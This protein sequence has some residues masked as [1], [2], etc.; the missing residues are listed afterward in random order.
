[1][2]AIPGPFVGVSVAAPARPGRV[3]ARGPALPRGLSRKAQL[4][5]AAAVFL[6]ISKFHGFVGVL[7]T[8]RAPFILSIIGLAM[9]AMQMNRWR[10]RDL[11]RHWIPKSTLV[12]LVI[13]TAG[14][15]LA[16]NDGK[17]FF[18]MKDQVL[19]V[20]LLALM[21][22]A[23]CRTRAGVK[24]IVKTLALAAITAGAMAL[25]EGRTDHSGRLSGA[26]AYDPNDL[27]LVCGVG[28]P[29]TA[30][31]IADKSNGKWRWLLLAGLPI[32]LL[33]MVKSSSRG[34]FL[35]ICAILFGV[36]IVAIR[37][38]NGKLGKVAA[39]TVVCGL[40]AF[41]LLPASYT[42]NL[43][44]ILDDNDYNRT[45]SSGRT[46]VWKR[47]MGYALSHPLTG[48]G[49][50]NYGTAEGNISELARERMPGQGL[51]WSAAHNSVVQMAAETGLIGGTLFVV[52]MV[53]SIMGL[54]RRALMASWEADGYLPAFLGTAVMAFFVGGFFL[55]FA[56]YELPWFLFAI[57]SGVLLDYAYRRR[58]ERAARA[59]ARGAPVSGRTLRGGRP[60]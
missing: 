25:L 47:G 17:A 5:I 8:I 19:T 42:E 11:V 55:S 58:A 36:I 59:A 52:L 54:T 56:W 40:L 37:S 26:Y 3:K 45:S 33:T 39:V 14:I 1:M 50:D 23:V 41:P 4:V 38:R 12:I 7:A 48:V 31:W 18:F 53:G 46:Q 22:W 29:L 21:V 15:P 16:L 51:K 32:L 30:W 43:K 20:I 28:V 24:L 6:P 60:G 9:I 35:T 44:T 34:G 2:T 57:S 13:A 10:P 49:L 27:A